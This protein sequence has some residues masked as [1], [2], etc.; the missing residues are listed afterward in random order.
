MSAPKKSREA[1]PAPK[2][3][4]PA[5]EEIPCPECGGRGFTIHHTLY[6]GTR[7]GCRACEGSGRKR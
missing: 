6:S 3:D 1:A 7:I 5:R 4:A 2:A